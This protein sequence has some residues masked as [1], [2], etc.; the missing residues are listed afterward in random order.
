MEKSKKIIGKSTR[1][2]EIKI[3]NKFKLINDKKLNKNLENSLRN[4]KNRLYRFLYASLANIY[5]D[6]LNIRFCI[7]KYRKKN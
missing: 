6:L 7:R 1:G 4:L 5:Y 2:K 3:I